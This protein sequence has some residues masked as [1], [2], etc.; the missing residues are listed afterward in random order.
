MER[1]KG[2]NSF[3]LAFALE[4][5]ALV[6]VV[7]VAWTGF[8]NIWLRLLFGAVCLVIFV[9]L[10]GAYFVPKTTI[11][12]RIPWILWGKLLLLSVPAYK[13]ARDGENRVAINYVL[14]VLSH[15]LLLAYQV[16]IL[17]KIRSY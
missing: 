13:M 7:Y 4:L 2:L 9:V 11:R 12:M 6:F 3:L 14:V 8:A 17:K 5:V 15:L 10:L 16:T 1:L